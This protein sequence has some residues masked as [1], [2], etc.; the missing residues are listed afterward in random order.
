MNRIWTIVQ[1]AVVTAAV[2]FT[3][4][5]ATDSVVAPEARDPAAKLALSPSLTQRILALDPENV[6]AADVRDTLSQAPAPRVILIHGGVYPVHL[7][8]TSFAQ[9]LVGMGYPERSIRMPGT[10]DWSHNPYLPSDR[11]AGLI[12]WSYENDGM[13]PMLI[14]H[15]QGG[16]QVVKVLHDLAGTFAPS[17]NVWNPLTGRTEPRTTIVDPLTRQE[18]PVVGVQVSFA[19]AVGA[20]GPSFIFPNNWGVFGRLQ[21][22]PDTAVQFNGY[23][24]GIDWFIV[25]FGGPGGNR[26]RPLGKTQI[27]NVELPAGYLHVSV[28]VTH[29]LPNKDD[30]RAFVDAYRAVSEKPDE[31]KMPGTYADNVY[32]AADNWH[33]I[34]KHWVLELQRMISA[35]GTR[36]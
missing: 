28:P 17:V 19:S 36:G 5:C 2:V 26:F 4:G 34:K 24:I 23:F 31:S 14:G 29:H 11:L 27:R 21:D 35:K 12:A 22:I 32:Y 10:N 1:R 13:R 18:R 8:M 25:N 20:G 3:A 30:L 33:G 7:A 6:T 16:I 15:S 9:F